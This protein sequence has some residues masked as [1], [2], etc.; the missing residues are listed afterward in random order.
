MLQKTCRRKQFRI[1]LIPSGARFCVFIKVCSS[2]IAWNIQ[3]AP[4][5]GDVLS[6]D[7]LLRSSLYVIYKKHGVICYFLKAHLLNAL[8]TMFFCDETSATRAIVTSQSFLKAIAKPCVLPAINLCLLWFGKNI[9]RQVYGFYDECLRKYGSVTVWRYCTEI[10]DYLSLSAIVDGKIFCVHGG[11]SPSIQTLDQV[12]PRCHPGTLRN[13]YEGAFLSRTNSTL[14][15]QLRTSCGDVSVVECPP[16]NRKVGC[17][18]HGHWVNRRSAAQL[19]SISLNRPGKKQN[20]GFDLPSIA[21]AQKLRKKVHHT[22]RIKA[23]HSNWRDRAI[24][25]FRLSSTYLPRSF[26]RCDDKAR[27]LLQETKQIQVKGYRKS[28]LCSCNM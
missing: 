27:L 11:L 23:T 12:M 19:K 14:K 7:H 10:F 13:V 2:T 1:G 21:T 28:V 4:F 20:S 5:K 6:N 24:C 15:D 17:S 3:G 16:L 25:N 26:N 18:I 9:K 8:L 22:V